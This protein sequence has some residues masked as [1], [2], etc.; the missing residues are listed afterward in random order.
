MK[1]APLTLA[2]AAAGLCT[3]V[4]AADLIGTVTDT[5]GKPIAGAILSVEGAHTQVKT[6]AKGQYRLRVADNSH[7]HLHASADQF[8]HQQRDIQAG[9][10]TLTENFT[11]APVNMENI[12]VTGTALGRSVLESS[13]PV[14][15]LTE[16]KLRQATEPSLGD[17]LERQPG[18]QA[19]HFGPASSR[20]IIRGM[21]GPRVKVLENGL[22]VGDASTVSADHAVTAEA[23]TARQIE[24]LRGPGTLLYGNGAIGGVVNVVDQRYSEQPVDGLN[25]AV[26]GRYST[27]DNE[28]TAVANLNGGNGQYNWHLDGTR[29]RAHSEK[30][31]GDAIA[32]IA[33]PS[34]RLA[35]SQLS[36]DDFAAGVGYT[37]ERGFVGVSGSRT[38]NLYGIPSDG[39]PTEPPIS[40]NMKK[41][42]WQ[43][44][45]GLDEPLPGFSKLRVDG[46]YTHYEHAEEDNGVPGT[47]FTNKYSEGRMSLYNKPWGEWQ[48]VM[49]VHLTH[50]NFSIAGDE[51]L[52]P[53]TVTDGTAAYLVQE[54]NVGDFRFELGGRLEHYRLT[55]DP[56]NLE[57]LGGANAYQP[58][59][60][61]DNNL[62]LSA[63]TV[64]HMTPGYNLSLALTRAERSAT[65]E[66]LYS[67]GPHDAT[68]TFE[69]GA[70]YQLGNGTVT[71]L[72]SKPKQE[73]ANNLD[74]TLRKFE[75]S[76]SGTF[77]VY[78][79]KVNNYFYEHDTGLVAADL[80]ADGD[81]TPVYQYS[82]GNATLYGYEAQATFNMTDL[83]SLDLFS[84]YT[85]GKLD[86]GGN[87]PRISPMRVGAR[88]NFDLNDWHA[89][90]GSTTYAKQDKVAENETTTS[91]YTLLDGSVSYHVYTST[92][93]L[94]V[95]LKGNNLT[96]REARP[97]T[98]LLKAIAPLPGR[99][100]TL[101]VRYTF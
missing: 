5:A 20:P 85:R 101:G 61:T 17:T 21:G 87:L 46:G 3:P 81:N 24:I 8:E 12:V 6:D 68:R 49:G 4:F 62:S 83:W 32:G 50:R 70:L 75:G 33:N 82:Q 99:S 23:S 96:N 59:N 11:L 39:D 80:V 35:N 72:S 26:E 18:V 73:I 78:Y 22:A 40:I 25:G 42:S 55:A 43:L 69:V 48:G 91:G 27:G 14:S 16:D 77:S 53:D 98:S 57:T 15:V 19:S 88:L 58:T 60:L 30:I 29:R 51:A 7:I 92:G 95:F 38:E 36:L 90:L 67:Y 86:N 93:D 97:H 54:R 28:R 37:G 1:F 79:N 76:W 45:G 71:P 31:P 100:F 44:H 63:G 9:T 47:I 56:M 89:D 13:T 84:D 64:W 10:Q 94:L 34:G 65:P 52:T 66:E 74:L 2:L 41:T